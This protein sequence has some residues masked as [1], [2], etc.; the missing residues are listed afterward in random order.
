M[1][2]EELSIEEIAEVR[3]AEGRSEGHAEGRVD[4]KTSIA[5][6]LLTEGSTHEFIQ[7]ITGLDIKTIQELSVAQI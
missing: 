4:E 3:Y 2:F 7:K 6:N 5:R 1:L